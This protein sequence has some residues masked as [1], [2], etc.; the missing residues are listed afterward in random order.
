MLRPALTLIYLFA[1]PGAGTRWLQFSSSQRSSELCLAMTWF[2]WRVTPV[3][4]TTTTRRSRTRNRFVFKMPP[5]QDSTGRTTFRKDSFSPVAANPSPGEPA[6]RRGARPFGEQPAHQPAADKPGQRLDEKVSGEM[7]MFCA[8]PAAHGEVPHHCRKLVRIKH[9]PRGA[10]RQPADVIKRAAQQ[11]LRAAYQAAMKE[12][13]ERP[14]I[15]EGQAFRWFRRK[16]SKIVGSNQVAHEESQ[17]GSGS[18]SARRCATEAGMQEPVTAKT[19][20]ALSDGPIAPQIGLG[21]R[22]NPGD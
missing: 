17:R 15:H 22:A 8:R 2:W 18:L 4:N 20:A 10:M 21:Q 3:R 9:K 11:A 5:R 12:P 13:A 1:G 16:K 6:P 7:L 14:K 19:A